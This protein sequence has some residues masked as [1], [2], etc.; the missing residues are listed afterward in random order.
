MAS[1]LFNLWETIRDALSMGDTGKTEK[2]NRLA[3]AEAATL[4]NVQYV[5]R[6]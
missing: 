3:A 4:G 1:W 5:R 6:L 2:I